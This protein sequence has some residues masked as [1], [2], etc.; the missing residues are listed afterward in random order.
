[1]HSSKT[2]MSF[3]FF[4][5]NNSSKEFVNF[6]LDERTY[7]KSAKKQFTFFS[8]LPYIS[9][10]KEME[11]AQKLL[12]NKTLGDWENILAHLDDSLKIKIIEKFLL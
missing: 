6:F 10:K 5:C 4:S 12:T 11:I 3:I 2:V 8:S 7:L 9:N 1:M